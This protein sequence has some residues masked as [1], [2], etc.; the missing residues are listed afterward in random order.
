LSS[1]TSASYPQILQKIIEKQNFLEKALLNSR[2]RKPIDYNHHYRADLRCPLEPGDIVMVEPA[3]KFGAYEIRSDQIPSVVVEQKIHLSTDFTQTLGN[4]SSSAGTITTQM[5]A[6]DLNIDEIGIYKVFPEDFGYSLQIFQPTTVTR[7]SNK[8]GAWFMSGADINKSFDNHYQ[9]LIPE[10]MVF[11][12]RTPVTMKATSTDPNTIANPYVRVKVYGYQLPIKKLP[13][14]STITR[15]DPRIVSN[16]WVG[17][18]S[19]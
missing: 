12:D 18:P 2:V 17:T 8:L 5:T 7:F 1:S 13:P 15:G 14:D 9:G 11:E 4:L 3:D 6:L 16:I 10:I 19:K